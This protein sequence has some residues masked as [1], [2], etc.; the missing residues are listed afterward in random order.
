MTARAKGSAI[1]SM[2]LAIA[3]T[4]PAAADLTLAVPP[5]PPGLGDAVSTAFVVPFKAATG[6]DVAVRETVVGADVALVGGPALLAGCKDGSL[7]KVDWA[8][9]GGRDR[10][11]PGMATDCGVGAVVDTTVLAWDRDK[12]QGAPGWA[13]FWDVA[14]VPGKRGLRR[15][16]RSN[17]EIALMADGVAAGDIYS[18]LATDQGVERAFRKLDQ[19]KPY[20]VW[21]DDDSDPLRLLA[22]GEALI[23]SAPATSVLPPHGV[24]TH[25]IAVQW[26]GGLQRVRSWAVPSAAQD[27]ANATKFLRFAT[28]PKIAAKLV[29]TGSWGPTSVGALAGLP[30]DKLWPVPTAP[31]N[32]AAG[33]MVN[34]QFWQDNEAKLSKRFDA[35][36]NR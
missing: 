36:M 19:L 6:L 18:T 7:R 32:L 1:L 34:E 25:L 3:A 33:L 4:A 27:A 2:L 16:V 22:S 13:E 8:A 35:W 23:T 12:V 20:V 26:A 24:A 15:G 21:W 17:L 14:K 28:D 31:A 30:A 10:L 29:E 11:L 9:I 5:A